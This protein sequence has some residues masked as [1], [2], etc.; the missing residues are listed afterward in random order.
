MHALSKHHNRVLPP[1]ERVVLSNTSFA[2]RTHLRQV[3]PNRWDAR[4]LLKDGAT[5]EPGT[6]LQ[7]RIRAEFQ[8][9]DRAYWVDRV[10]SV[11]VKGCP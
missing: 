8:G 10:V 11:A 1:S 3:R 4:L 7:L 9:D 6:P 5:V 2:N